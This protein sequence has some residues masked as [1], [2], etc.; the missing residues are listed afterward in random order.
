MAEIH[1]E[2]EIYR[3]LYRLR[4]LREE[5]QA[6]DIQRQ[7]ELQE[8][9]DW[10]QPAKKARDAEINEINYLIDLYAQQKLAEDPYW[11]Y[12][13]RNGSVSVRRSTVWTHDDDKLIDE[14]PDQYINRKVKWGEYKKTLTPLD[15][16]KVVDENGEI[17]DGITAERQAKIQIKPTSSDGKTVTN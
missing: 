13:S 10:Y 4:K 15:N 14:V 16:G 7:Q 17:V 5:Q 12:R 2:D 6:D 3:K 8:T 9:E 11:R 1:D